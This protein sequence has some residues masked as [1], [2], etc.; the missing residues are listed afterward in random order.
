MGN[1]KTTID[2]NS[3]SIYS[4]LSYTPSKELLKLTQWLTGYFSSA[5]QAD[6]SSDKYHVDVRLRMR[7]IWPDSTNGIWIYVEQAYADDTLNPYRQRIYKL[8]EENG[9]IV[10]NIFGIADDSLYVMAWQKPELLNNL[11]YKDLLPKTNCGL[12]FSWNEQNDCFEGSTS[13]ND[14]GAGIPGVTYITSESEIYNNKFTS[15]DL[16]YDKNGKVVMGPFSPY[17]FDKLSNYDCS[18]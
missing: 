8:Y 3:D 14:C 2:E 5:Q 13:G 9:Q 4:E 7:Q 10:D 15:W 12:V 1:N 16:G 11:T 18:K 17:I 6:T